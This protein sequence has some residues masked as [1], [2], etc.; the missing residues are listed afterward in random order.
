[1]LLATMSDSRRARIREVL[2]A[3]AG[4]PIKVDT[5]S[6]D[7]DL[8][9]AGMASFASVN[10]MLGLEEAFEIEFPDSMLTREVFQSV[11][12]IATAVGSLTD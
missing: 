6:D 4:L 5:I 10:V 1:M 11:D 12:A 7:A 3:H 8:F 9:Q 2:A